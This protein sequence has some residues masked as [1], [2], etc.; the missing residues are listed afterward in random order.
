M[1]AANA[2]GVRRQ[3]GVTRPAGRAGALMLAAIFAT[4]VAGA[5][6]ATPARAEEAPARRGFW[7]PGAFLSVETRS[8]ADIIGA[9]SR[10]VDAVKPGVGQML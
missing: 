8:A 6:A 2:M 9:V 7:I 4:V 3:S 1:F 10:M 5:L